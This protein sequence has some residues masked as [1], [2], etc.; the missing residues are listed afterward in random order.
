MHVMAFVGVASEP[1]TSGLIHVLHDLGAI[2]Y[3]PRVV[4]DE[5]V[6]VR[7]DPGA[8][9]EVGAYGIPAPLGVAAVPLV[10]DL[11]VVP[12]LAFTPDGHRLGQGG[13]YYDRYLALLRADCVSVGVCFH[14]QLVQSVP[15][16]AHDQRVSRV[17]TDRM[18]Q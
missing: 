8:P 4:G 18:Q 14:E 7:H 1:D 17:V 5:I 2:V 3:L 12:G 9:M 6:A 16:E 11:V 10:I 13:G 15:G